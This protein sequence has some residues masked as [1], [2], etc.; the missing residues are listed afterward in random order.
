MVGAT[1]VDD[2]MA[3]VAIV[4]IVIIGDAIVDAAI[5]GVTIAGVAIARAAPIV[6]I[7]NAAP[8]GPTIRNA[9]SSHRASHVGDEPDKQVKQGFYNGE[10]YHRFFATWLKYYDFTFL[11]ISFFSPLVIE[12]N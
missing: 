9:K 4:I 8:I 7:A 2:S 10:K 12:F 6:A 5:V 1:L 3:S 11:S